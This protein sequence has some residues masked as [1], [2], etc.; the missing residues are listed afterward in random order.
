[1]SI[2]TLGTLGPVAMLGIMRDTTDWPEYFSTRFRDFTP[3]E[4]TLP[5]PFSDEHHTALAPAS[6]SRALVHL[7]G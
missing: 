3:T 6:I 4:W 2:S 7:Y 1:M 5:G